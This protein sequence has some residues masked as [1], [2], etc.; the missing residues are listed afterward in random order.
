MAAVQDY[1]LEWLENFNSGVML[2]DVDRWREENIS[3][4]L[5][6]LTELHHQE[7][8]GDQGVLNILFKDK[9]KALDKIYNFMVGLDSFAHLR[10]EFNWY[11]TDVS[12]IIIHYTT[13]KKPWTSYSLTRFRDVWWFY[14]GLSWQDILLRNTIIKFGYEELI[15][16]PQ[17]H[18]V[19]FTDSANMPHLEE[20]IKKF[21]EV[22]F[23]ILAY[24]LF[25]DSVLDLQ[26]YSNVS[27]YSNFNPFNKKAVLSKMDFYLDINYGIEIEN[28]VE[29]VLDM[30]IPVFAY[31]DT[32]HKQD[33]RIKCV[34]GDSA[35]ELIEEI[36]QYLTFSKQGM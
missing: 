25:A 19:I 6:E 9:W 21:S 3:T 14:N 28:I 15:I 12:P 36:K 4:K 20:L 7:V 29:T 23:H 26:A 22:Q 33:E 24:T 35:T 16:P 10:G 18:A 2:I 11:K 34:S 32:C 17:A 13:E 31:L 27:L 1:Y 5:L 8:Y 30:G